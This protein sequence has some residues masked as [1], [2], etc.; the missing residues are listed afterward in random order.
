MEDEKKLYY[1]DDDFMFR[2][3]SLFRNDSSD[4]GDCTN[5]SHSFRN[6]KDV[7]TCKQHGIHFHCPTHPEIELDLVGDSDLKCRICGKDKIVWSFDSLRSKCLKALNSDQF[8]NAK[9]IRINDFYVPQAKTK[10]K[11]EDYWA[12][13][14]VKTDKDGDTIIVVYVGDNTDKKR[15]AQLFIKPEKGQFSHDHKDLDPSTIIS[16]IEITFKDKKIT[17]E[18]E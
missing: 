6:G 10:A 18:F 3:C 13:T 7:Y 14:D 16:K 17:H 1:L 12:T 4:F 2:C 15:K 8:K 5:W 11:T 9:L